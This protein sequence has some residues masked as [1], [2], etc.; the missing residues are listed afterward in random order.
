VLLSLLLKLVG[1]RL[2][3]RGSQPTSSQGGLDEL[4]CLTLLTV[5]MKSEAIFTDAC[6]AR[7]RRGRQVQK[8]QPTGLSSFRS[9]PER[10]GGVATA[11]RPARQ[12]FESLEGRAAALA[13]HDGAEAERK[14]N[15]AE[16]IR[17]KFC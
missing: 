9:C 12:G 5:L 1:D 10:G 13:H 11:P 2:P 16:E 8:G 17:Y 6:S 4:D 14:L 15:D 7:G 3:E